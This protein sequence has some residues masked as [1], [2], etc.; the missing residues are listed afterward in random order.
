MIKCLMYQKDVTI[1]ILYVITQYQIY[2]AKIDR[3]KVIE[4]LTLLVTDVN[5]PLSVIDRIS[6]KQ[7]EILSNVI[8][9]LDLIDIQ[10]TALNIRRFLL[11]CTWNIFFKIDYRP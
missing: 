11:K 9:K 3:L 7:V 1:L 10:N 2:R 6:K 4:K 8:N 5:I